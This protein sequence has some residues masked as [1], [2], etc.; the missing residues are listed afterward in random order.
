MPQVGNQHFP[1]TKAGT[2]AA[3][4]TAKK[5]GQPMVVKPPKAM[6]APKKGK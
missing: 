5:S 4:M 3:K 2:K 6:K 1:Y